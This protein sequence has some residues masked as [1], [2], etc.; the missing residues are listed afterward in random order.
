MV[1]Y[2]SADDRRGIETN[3]VD[4]MKKFNITGT[5]FPNKHY[6]VDLT[7]RVAQIK[8]MVDDGAYFCIN[9]GRQYGKTTTLHALTVGLASDY[10]VYAISFEGL[11]NASYET[12]RHLALR[13][14]L[15]PIPPREQEHLHLKR[16]P[17]RVSVIVLQIGVRS[18]RWLGQVLSVQCS[19]QMLG[20]R[21]FTRANVAFY[22]NHSA[23]HNHSSCL[24]RDVAN[25][26]RNYAANLERKIQRRKLAAMDFDYLL[27]LV[28][29]KEN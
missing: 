14:L 22:D 21:A 20:K 7:S 4:A 19:R 15:R 10:E 28:G 3:G 18:I 23:V 27:N 26:R 17:R 5:C 29:I 13:I 24:F 11:D 9:R 16:P 1:S 8:A 2:P 12:E 25:L 6:M